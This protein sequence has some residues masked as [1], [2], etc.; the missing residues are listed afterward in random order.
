MKCSVSHWRV[1]FYS[2]GGNACCSS[3][4]FLASNKRETTQDFILPDRK[5]QE[6]TNRSTRGGRILSPP[7]HLH[8]HSKDQQRSQ[9]FKRVLIRT[10]SSF[11]FFCTRQ[12]AG[13][14]YE[15][16]LGRWRTQTTSHSIPHGLQLAAESLQVQLSS[17]LTYSPMQSHTI[18][19]SASS[20]STSGPTVRNHHSCMSFSKFSP[21]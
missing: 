21:L 15:S 18:G 6:S 8:A 17:V 9:C 11:V 10:V 16:L 4:F 13:I 20:A 5:V 1:S 12:V 19:D 2:L 3:V 14:H 7:Y